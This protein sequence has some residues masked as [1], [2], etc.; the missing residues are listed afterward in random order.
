ML[1]RG[2]PDPTLVVRADLQHEKRE[3]IRAAFIRMD[4]DPVGRAVPETFRARSFV[5]ITSDDLVGIR[6]F[7]D[8]NRSAMKNRGQ[9]VHK[10]ECRK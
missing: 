7:V 8:G 2:F 9:P 4:C 5:K 6:Q 3:F 10:M 1:G